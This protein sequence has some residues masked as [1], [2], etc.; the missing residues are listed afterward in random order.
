MLVSANRKRGWLCNQLWGY[1]GSLK[2]TPHCLSVTVVTGFLDTP[3]LC[4]KAL[5]E[6]PLRNPPDQYSYIRTVHLFFNFSSAILVLS[7]LHIDSLVL[8]FSHFFNSESDWHYVDVIWWQHG[9]QERP[10]KQK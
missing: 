5:A 6:G 4:S 8:F 2:V 10:R 1:D 3:S 9:Q 7:E